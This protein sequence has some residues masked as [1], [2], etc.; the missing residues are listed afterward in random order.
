[1]LTM[2]Q[3][4]FKRFREL[5]HHQTGI[6]LRDGKN[7]MLA[8]RL[9]RRLR[10][11]G[12]SS[13]SEYYDYLERSGDALEIGELINCVTTN[14]TSFFREM[15]HFEFLHDVL[16][17]ERTKA[18]RNGQSKSIRIWSAACST[19]EE[20]YSIAMSLCEA[21]S[22]GDSVGRLTGDTS[23]TTEY[24][25]AIASWK[26]EI[27]ASDIDTTVL[28]KAS[29][30]VY[31][32]DLL[33]GVPAALLKRYFLR[34]KGEMAGYVKIRPDI[35]KLLHFERINLM[36]KPWPL[37]GRFHVIFFRN[38]LIYFNQQTQ[39]VFLRRMLQLLEPRGYLILG[40][41]EHVPWLHDQI[42]PLN[43]TIFQLRERPE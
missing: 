2:D 16:V 25:A 41:S 42:H 37:S 12:L 14:K 22:G 43:H 30:G 36:D 23:A 7:V 28:D 13:F 15:H 5:I 38:A 10:H 11:H 31:R 9:T 21:L 8:S 4:D 29:R 3:R 6:W 34:G 32:D 26:L 24:A 39:D 33:D 27:V 20:P 35:R 18:A 17:P 40:H 1:M 19:G